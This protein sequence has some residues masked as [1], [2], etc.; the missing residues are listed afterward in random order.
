MYFFLLVYIYTMCYLY[1]HPI[2]YIYTHTLGFSYFIGCPRRQ[3][4]VKWNCLGSL[5]VVAYVLVK[6]TFRW[7]SELVW[8]LYSQNYSERILQIL[9]CVGDKLIRPHSKYGAYL[10]E[11]G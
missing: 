7:N 1:R 2:V 3:T 6:D 5:H 11:K 8:K 10:V 9:V 4:D